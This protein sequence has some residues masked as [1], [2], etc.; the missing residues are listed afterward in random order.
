MEV[1]ICFARLRTVAFENRECLEKCIEDVCPV[2]EAIK[3]R[4]SVEGCDELRDGI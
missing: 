2:Y 1:H 3:R 4:E